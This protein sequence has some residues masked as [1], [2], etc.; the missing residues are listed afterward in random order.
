MPADANVVDL[1]YAKESTFGTPPGGTYTEVR[2]TG[3]SLKQTTD[4]TLSNEI[5]SDR[6]TSDIIRTNVGAYT[7]GGPEHWWPAD[8]DSGTTVTDRG[9]VGGCNLTLHGG[10]T[11]EAV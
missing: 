4:T 11:I 7:G 10:V 1:R 6:A 9:S 3:E 8:G 2:Y 5:R